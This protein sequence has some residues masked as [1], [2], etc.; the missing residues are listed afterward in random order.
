M[1]SSVEYVPHLIASRWVAATRR[2]DPSA[3]KQ[4]MASARKRRKIILDYIAMPGMAIFVMYLF[5]S[6]FGVSFPSWTQAIVAVAVITGFFLEKTFRSPKAAERD[7]G[8]SL[9]DFNDMGARLAEYTGLS[10]KQLNMLADG[11]LKSITDDLLVSNAGRVLAS[12]TEMNGVPV[13][14]LGPDGSERVNEARNLD[15]MVAVFKS[16]G[17]ASEGLEH[18]YRLAHEKLEAPG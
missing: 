2:Q 8:R 9:R 14:H 11:Q 4:V 12:P 15:S 13:E 5:L 6:A 3:A 10:L 18:Y 16:F 1:S 7:A 17:L